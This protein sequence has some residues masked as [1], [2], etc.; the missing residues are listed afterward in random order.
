[1]ATHRRNNVPEAA[2]KGF[3]PM[4]DTALNKIKCEALF[5]KSRVYIKRALRMRRVDDSDEY[6]LWASLALE[7]LGKAA[8][9]LKHPSLVVNTKHEDSLFVAVGMDV[10]ADVKTINATT[11]FTRLGKLYSEFD[12]DIQK[13]CQQIAQRRNSEL[14]SAEQ[15]FKTMTV[16]KW[17]G[18]YWHACYTILY[19]MESSLDE[20]LE[21]KNVAEYQ[22]I[23]NMAIEVRNKAVKERINKACDKFMK[24]NK[25][26]REHH[27]AESRQL[28]P[29]HKMERVKGKYDKY[30]KVNCPACKCLGIMAG[31]QFRENISEEREE[32]GIW[33]TV[34]NEFMGEEFHC[35]TCELSLVGN[36]EFKAAHLEN[37]HWEQNDLDLTHEREC[38]N[39]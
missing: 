39:D 17:E 23:L 4:P 10:K 21:A 33:E 30:W 15:P 13:L 12:Q 18:D 5:G 24:L 1:M 36:V 25:S 7:I 3:E 9:A 29:K 14:H 35:P 34:D 27:A 31:D 11:L 37:M 19:I 28:D 32:S 20:W 26:V 8:L 6:Q 38:G 16:D 22:Q 2:L